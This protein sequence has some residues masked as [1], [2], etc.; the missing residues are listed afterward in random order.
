[1]FVKSQFSQNSKLWPKFR[2]L[3]ENLH[4][5]E[6]CSERS[7]S[8]IIGNNFCL[9]DN[10]LIRFLS[11][12]LSLFLMTST[13][14]GSVVSGRL[15]EELPAPSFHRLFIRS[16]PPGVIAVL[17]RG[18]LK[19]EAPDDPTDSSYELTRGRRGDALEIRKRHSDAI[20]LASGFPE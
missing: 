18:H 3:S 11:Q 13:G 16:N 4:I 10:R 5:H 9:L 19:I 7:S 8:S 6:S 14:V 1:M 17:T 2:E 12:Y 15:S 20:Y